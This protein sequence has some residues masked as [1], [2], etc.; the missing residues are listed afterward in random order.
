MKRSQ[1]RQLF[2][3]KFS[4]RS[5]LGGGGL[6]RMCSFGV[7]SLMAGDSETQALRLHCTA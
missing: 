2:S 3:T 4:S 6:K 1:K 7:L 5:G